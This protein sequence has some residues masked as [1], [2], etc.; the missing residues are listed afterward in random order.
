MHPLLILNY[1]HIVIILLHNQLDYKR[2]CSD[3]SDSFKQ[4]RGLSMGN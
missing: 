3:K 1:I 2:M 4:T